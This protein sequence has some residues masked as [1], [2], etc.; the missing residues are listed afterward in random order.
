MFRGGMETACFAG[1]KQSELKIDNLGWF[2][3]TSFNIPGLG[4]Q[5]DLALHPAL[6]IKSYVAKTGHLNLHDCFLSSK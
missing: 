5:A 1:A 2:P 6:L 4:R 3:Q